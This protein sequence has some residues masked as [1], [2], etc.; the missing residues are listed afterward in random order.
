MKYQTPFIHLMK[1]SLG[2]F[3]YDVNRNKILKVPANV[4]LYLSN[5]EKS[6]PAQEN[7]IFSYIEMLK[8]KGYLKTNRVEIPEHP[9]TEVYDAY[10]KNDL[11]HLT[12]Q[13]T[14]M[15]NLNC[16]YCAY[17]GGYYNRVHANK[18]MDMEIVRK[19]IDFFIK[20]SRDS[21]R[22]AISFYGGEPL[23]AF[24]LI[25][26]SV[27]YALE[28]AEG[29]KVMFNFTTNGTLLTEEKMNFLIEHDFIILIS[30]DGPKEIHDK[31]RVF[32]ANN[33]GSFDSIMKNVNMLKQNY[34]DFY[35]KNISFNSV[36]DPTN[37]FSNINDFI[38]NSSLLEDNRFFSTVINDNYA[39]NE[40]QYSKEFN[41]ELRYEMFK[42]LLHKTGWLEVTEVSPLVINYLS[43]IKRIAYSMNNLYQNEIGVKNHRGGPC[44][45]GVQRLFVTV[46]GD[47]HPCERVS[48]S[49]PVTKIGHIETGFDIQKAK[50]ILNLEQK[51]ADKCKNCW[52][53]YYCKIC[54]AKA[55][56]GIEISS[57]KI[58]ISCNWVR[59]QVEE[60]LQNL[61]VL[62]ELGY[63]PETDI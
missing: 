38:T 13:V 47:F 51:T 4:Y 9:V 28:R 23:L 29:R 1:N 17:S 15:C 22:F 43:N 5:N 62:S 20:H 39:K 21:K 42:L 7:E 8:D 3:I 34:P 10:L 33:K 41:I 16:K 24:D 48:E 55:D 45:P 26:E 12:L 44:M 19:S 11:C 30:L 37:R 32:A 27:I 2:Y 35:E 53:Y 6:P 18:W 61:C 14:Q 25:K 50:Q 58:S 52:A 54:V 60:E 49:S 36:L 40:I 56:D 46:H 57:S 59:Q 31:N 63:S